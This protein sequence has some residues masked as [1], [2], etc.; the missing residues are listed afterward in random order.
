[1]KTT[2]SFLMGMAALFVFST[3]ITSCSKSDNNSQA[4]ASITVHLTDAPGMY[5][6]VNVDI[7]AVEVST[8]GGWVS[9]P[10]ARPGVY[11]LLALSNGVDTI[12]AP[13]TAI[14]AG[15]ISQFRLTLGTNNSVVVK[16]QSYP[17]KTPSGQQSGLKLNVDQTLTANNAYDIWFDFNAGSSVVQQGNGNYSLKPVIR[18]FTKETSG[19][20]KGSVFPSNA[21]VLAINGTDTSAA[22]PNTDGS[23]LFTGLPSGTYTVQYSAVGLTPISISGVNVSYGVVTTVNPVTLK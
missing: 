12:L 9:L 22:L 14:P 10:L 7:Q 5:D 21:I 8:A 15:T 6:Q 4:K 23:F 19:Q 16:G 13:N 18:A 2:N 11:N 20:I 1:M 3:A 17:L